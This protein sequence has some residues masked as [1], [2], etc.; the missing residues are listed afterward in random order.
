MLNDSGKFSAVVMGGKQQRQVCAGQRDFRRRFVP[1]SA[2]DAMTAPDIM[3]GGFYEYLL[4]RKDRVT[5]YSGKRSRMLNTF[6]A[7]GRSVFFTVE[8]QGRPAC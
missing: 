1:S 3:H 8:F 6:A 7:S 5:P 2:E 4:P